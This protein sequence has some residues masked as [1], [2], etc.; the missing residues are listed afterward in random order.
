MNSTWLYHVEPQYQDLYMAEAE[1]TELDVVKYLHKSTDSMDKLAW[2]MFKAVNAEELDR[3]TQGEE[4][5][6][7]QKLV[8][9]YSRYANHPEFMD[10]VRHLIKLERIKARAE[11]EEVR[12]RKEQ[13][14]KVFNRDHACPVCSE[15][16]HNNSR[17]HPC[18]KCQHVINDRLI[19]TKERARMVDSWLKTH[20]ASIRKP[21]FVS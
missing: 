2:Q 14:Q 10:F 21:R 8:E 3:L 9:N 13:V 17:W 1:P 5:S 4:W 15:I 11:A 12:K 6:E 19:Q 18:P 20:P 7:R 16:D